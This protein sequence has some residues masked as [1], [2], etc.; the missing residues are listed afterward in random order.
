[1]TTRSEPPDT[2]TTSGIEYIKTAISGQNR[3]VTGIA[4][5]AA[6]GGFLF[7]YGLPPA[8]ARQASSRAGYRTLRDLLRLR[9]L[10]GRHPQ[11]SLRPGPSGRCGRA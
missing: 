10:L 4:L 11:G 3:F 6:L 2:A 9:G 7:G 1:M 5:L 8:A